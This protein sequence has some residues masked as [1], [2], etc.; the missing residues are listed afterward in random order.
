MY[1]TI[2][3]MAEGFKRKKINDREKIRVGA[4]RDLNRAEML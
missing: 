1:K 3:D 4:E 2:L